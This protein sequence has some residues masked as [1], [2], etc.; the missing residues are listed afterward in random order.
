L[1]RQLGFAWD[2]L[3]V[4]IAPWLVLA[5]QILFVLIGAFA[6]KAV[7]K[8]LF[9]SHQ[10]TSSQRLSFRQRWPIFLLAAVYILLFWAG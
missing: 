3:G 4:N 1:G 10:E 2:F 8:R 9:N 6:S 5:C 7:L